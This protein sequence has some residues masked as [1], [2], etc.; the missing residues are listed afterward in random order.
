MIIF[1][2]TP[3]LAL[4][5]VLL[6]PVSVEA[7]FEW[8]P[9]AKMVAPQPVIVPVPVPVASVDGGEVMVAVPRSPVVAEPLGDTSSSM[10][11]APTPLIQ[12]QPIENIVPQAQAV[13]KSGGLYI[14]PY[15]MQ[16]NQTMNRIADAQ[17][18]QVVTEKS[19]ALNPVQLGGGM[20]TG[21]SQKQ[22]YVSRQI[23]TSNRGKS[24]A[25]IGINSLTPMMGDEPAPLPGYGLGSVERQPMRQYAQAVGF[26][27]N[28]PLAL[29]I[30][31]VI[32]S[33][34]TH[35]FDG[36]ISPSAMV[37]W[38]G[39]KPWNVVLNDMLRDENMTADI[40]GNVVVIKPSQKI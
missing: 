28:L 17:I 32:P 26:G 14:D 5:A 34:Y 40:E 35:R 3:T 19:G 25:S 37:D 22:T 12:V 20:T 15:P 24:I 27:K 8:Q 36:D 7:G 6:F 33:E 4:I 30:S 1:N 31:Q 9:P 23:P 21:V 13:V 29:A 2:K 18:N 11:G 16:N 10:M 39:G 38:D